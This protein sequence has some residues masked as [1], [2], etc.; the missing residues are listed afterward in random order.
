MLKWGA[1]CKYIMKAGLLPPA[2]DVSYVLQFMKK[3]PLCIHLYG[4]GGP[5]PPPPN[6]PKNKIFVKLVDD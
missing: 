6:Q 2:V 4:Y 5:P 1:H 3:N